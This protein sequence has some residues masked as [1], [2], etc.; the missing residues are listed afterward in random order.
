[1]GRLASVFPLFSG[2]DSTS[3]NQCVSI[4]RQLARGGRTVVCTIH[5]P[6]AKIFEMFDNV[7]TCLWRYIY[8]LPS[9]PCTV[10][11]PHKWL[12]P[13]PMNTHSSQCWLY[14]VITSF[15][16]TLVQCCACNTPDM[17]SL[18][19]T[20]HSLLTSLEFP[21]NWCDSSCKSVASWFE[22]CSDTLTLEFSQ[23]FLEPLLRGSNFPPLEVE[24]IH[25][26]LGLCI[27]LWA[28]TFLVLLSINAVFLFYS[29]TCWPKVNVS[30]RAKCNV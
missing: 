17:Y 10:Y 4:L 13:C 27:R 16:I 5:Q 30:T 18:T 20:V 24:I 26:D 21:G 3:T 2:L 14:I 11:V 9:H 23:C 28:H 15:T 12:K 22:W 19:Y 7:S 29:F 6:S 1:M 8:N 25:R